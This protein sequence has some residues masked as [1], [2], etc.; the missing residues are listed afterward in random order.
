MRNMPRT[1]WKACARAP[2]LYNGLAA[3]GNLGQLLAW[4]ASCISAASSDS[5]SASRSDRSA[6][7]PPADVAGIW[8]VALSSAIVWDECSTARRVTIHSVTQ[9]VAAQ[10]H[11]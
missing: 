2:T 1:L 7:P 9:P 5:R 6:S 4:D 8:G 11:Q 3:A 10:E